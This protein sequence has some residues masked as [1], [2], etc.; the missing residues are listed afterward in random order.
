VSD[1]GE[2]LDRRTY[3]W[4]HAP[5]LVP[6]GPHILVDGR[7]LCIIRDHESGIGEAG[8]DESIRECSVASSIVCGISKAIEVRCRLPSHQIRHPHHF[9]FPL[10]RIPIN[11]GFYRGRTGFA[12]LRSHGNTTRRP[13][14][15]SLFISS[16]VR[17]ACCICSAIYHDKHTEP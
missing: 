11:L 16:M 17:S 15:S 10:C 8:H 1:L 9:P 14:I 13:V 7:P 2:I 12:Y 4:G 5:G 3:L 6:L